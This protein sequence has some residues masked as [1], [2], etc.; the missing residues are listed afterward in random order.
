MCGNGFL[1]AAHLCSFFSFCFLLITHFQSIHMVPCKTSKVSS[2][3][4]LLLFGTDVLVSSHVN[5]HYSSLSMLNVP[6]G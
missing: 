4:L 2:Q 1:E 6:H 5:H 3:Q